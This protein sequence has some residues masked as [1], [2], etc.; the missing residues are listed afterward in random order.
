MSTA[1]RTYFRGHN[2]LAL[3]DDVLGV[4][5]TYHFDHQGTMQRLTSIASSQVSTLAANAWGTELK[6]TGNTTNPHRYLANPGYYVHNNPAITYVRR[7]YLSPPTARW[8]SADPTGLSLSLS[9]YQYVL[10][11]PGLHSDPSGLILNVDSSC[12]DTVRAAVNCICE[13]IVPVTE[14]LPTLSTDDCC[15][16]TVASVELSTFLSK[17]YPAS[18]R[19]DS[20]RCKGF[21]GCLRRTDWCLAEQRRRL[22]LKQ[23]YRCLRPRCESHAASETWTIKCLGTENF[24]CRARKP[25]SYTPRFGSGQIILCTNRLKDSCPSCLSGY[26]FHELSHTCGFGLFGDRD[27]NPPFYCYE[28]Y[29]CTGTHLSDELTPNDVAPCADPAKLFP[30]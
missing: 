29:P 9:L 1:L 6:R 18:Q 16:T 21:L 22:W 12:P 17:C 10:N 11:S 23:H 26:I 4:S 15:G 20:S 24:T 27:E 28:H 5:S 13:K 3:R 19:P 2:L 8:A 25:C 7:R 30:A 14:V